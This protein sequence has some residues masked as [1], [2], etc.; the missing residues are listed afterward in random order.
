MECNIDGIPIFYKEY[1]E[2]V[3]VLC[4][5]GYTLD[6]RVM[7]GCVEPVLGALN[8]YKRIYLDL[9]GM[10][11]TPSSPNIKN[12]DDMLDLLKKFINKIIGEEEFLLVG[13]SY[14]G[15]LSMGLIHAQQRI[16]GLFLICPCTIAD[17]EKRHLPSADEMAVPLVETTKTLER[18]EKEIQPGLSAAD[19]TF[20][21]KY[22]KEGYGFSFADE[23]DNIKFHFPACIVLGRQDDAVGYMD[24]LKLIQNFT[25]ATFVVSDSTSHNLQIERTDL[26]ETCFFDWIERLG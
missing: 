3:P 23:M 20:T 7:E 8:G 13:E 17:V 19:K 12:A 25:R 15:Y 1:G 24:A 14:G 26:F 11:Q 5:H 6:H 2:G 4:L 9:P 18:Y 21:S 10:G 22:R 16:K